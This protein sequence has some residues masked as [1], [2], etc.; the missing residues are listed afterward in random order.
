MKRHFHQPAPSSLTT[1]CHALG[2][3][4]IPFQVHRIVPVCV[5]STA[6]HALR[7]PSTLCFKS[8]PLNNPSKLNPIYVMSFSM[9]NPP[10][11]CLYNKLNP[12]LNP[13]P[14][15]SPQFPSPNK[16]HA[17]TPCHSQ[18]KSHLLYVLSHCKSNPLYTSTKLNPVHSI[19]L[20]I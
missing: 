7:T 16:S 18:Y 5:Y 20:S 3:L 2:V 11:P 9:S 8:H 10:L 1:Y 19:R 12:N 6:V 14:P 13:I 17:F 15:P 4:S